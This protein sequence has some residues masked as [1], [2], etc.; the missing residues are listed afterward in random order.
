M[1]WRGEK[2]GRNGGVEG[3]EKGQKGGLQ[4]EWEDTHT[5]LGLGKCG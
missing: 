3:V 1:S 2:E 5:E 4:A